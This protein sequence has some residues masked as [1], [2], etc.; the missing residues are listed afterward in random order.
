MAGFGG[1][2]LDHINCFALSAC[3]GVL[4][5]TLIC[6]DGVYSCRCCSFIWYFKLNDA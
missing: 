6:G 5:V 2:L 3:S 1:A 4:K